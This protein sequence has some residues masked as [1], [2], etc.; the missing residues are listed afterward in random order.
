MSKPTLEDCLH[1]FELLN[2]NM[3]KRLQDKG[4]LDK[5]GR[6]KY[7]KDGKMKSMELTKEE[8]AWHRKRRRCYQKVQ[9]YLNQTT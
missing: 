7:D 3:F 1:A 8:Q 4:V 5:R 2:F 9:D 6:I